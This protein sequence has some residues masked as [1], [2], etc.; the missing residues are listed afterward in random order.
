[1]RK[2]PSERRVAVVIPL[3]ARPLCTHTT[4]RVQSKYA[5]ALSVK[6]RF[7]GI[8]AHFGSPALRLLMLLLLLL[9]LFALVW[10]G[11]VWLGR[12]CL[13]LA[14]SNFFAPLRLVGGRPPRQIS[15]SLQAHVNQRAGHVA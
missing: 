13:V 14:V 11:L 12:V 8:S 5:N 1:M 10:L 7:D 6:R 4:G 9:L 3:F 2:R 15:S